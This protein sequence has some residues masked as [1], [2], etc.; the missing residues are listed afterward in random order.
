MKIKT[1]AAAIAALVI[2]TSAPAETVISTPVMTDVKIMFCNCDGL[3]EYSVMQPW[4]YWFL[5]RT[6]EMTTIKTMV[7]EGWTLHAINNLNAKQFY[8]TFVKY[9]AP[10]IAAPPIEPVAPERAPPAAKL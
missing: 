5:G 6:D 2:S 3:W 10:P 1:I 4:P 7:L 8:I 9:D